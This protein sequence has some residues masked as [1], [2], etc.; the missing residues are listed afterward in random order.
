MTSLLNKKSVR[1]FALRMSQGRPFTRVS[2]TF[3][4]RIED[5][6]RTI[7]GQEVHRHPTIGKTLL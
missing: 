1:E 2:K 3:L 6:V 4:N 7:V 5:H